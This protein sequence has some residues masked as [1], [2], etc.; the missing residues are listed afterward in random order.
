MEDVMLT[1]NEDGRRRIV[2]EMDSRLK[3]LPQLAWLLAW[4]N[5]K[6]SEVKGSET[7]F[8]VNA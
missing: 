8:V 1:L 5:R 6:A 4:S 3:H 7:D 2:A